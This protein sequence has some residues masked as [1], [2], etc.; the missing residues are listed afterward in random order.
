MEPS[1][2]KNWQASSLFDKYINIRD[3]AFHPEA[4]G[5]AW[6][7]CKSLTFSALRVNWKYPKGKSYIEGIELAT[8][9]ELVL[10]FVG[11]LYSAA[12]EQLCVR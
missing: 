5:G 7:Q 6:N 8:V 11:N 1:L 4:A 9:I 12:S 2:T 3:R 10:G